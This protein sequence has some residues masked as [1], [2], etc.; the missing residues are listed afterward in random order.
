[1]IQVQY[2]AISSCTEPCSTLSYFLLYIDLFGPILSDLCS[3]S[4][5][6]HISSHLWWAISSHMEL[7]CTCSIWVI[8]LKWVKCKIQAFYEYDLSRRVIIQRTPPPPRVKRIYWEEAHA[9]LLSSHYMY[10]FGATRKTMR[11]RKAEMWGGGQAPWQQK[12]ALA[13][14]YIYFFSL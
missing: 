6:C 12:R 13:S 7:Y 10:L 4:F 8:W 3:I 1:M 2:W 5:S 11:K 14:T 9:V